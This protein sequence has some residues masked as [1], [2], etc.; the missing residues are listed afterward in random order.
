M[1]LGISYT[2]CSPPRCFPPKNNLVK[3]VWSFQDPG[4]LYSLLK[5]NFF[6][7]KFMKISASGSPKNFVIEIFWSKTFNYSKFGVFF[8]FKSPTSRGMNRTE[9]HYFFVSRSSLIYMYFARCTCMVEARDVCVCVCDV[10]AFSMSCLSILSLLEC[11][12]NATDIH[13]TIFL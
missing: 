5:K 8:K 13:K 9:F 10:R 3:I 6:A 11:M 12:L 2:L 7:K 4:L 1:H